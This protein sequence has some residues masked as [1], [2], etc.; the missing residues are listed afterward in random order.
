MR[1]RTNFL[2][3]LLPVLS[4]VWPQL[5][6]IDVFRFD[7]PGS[8]LT[9]EDTFDYELIDGDIHVTLEKSKPGLFK[10]LDLITKLLI[11]SS[12]TKLSKCLIEELND[13]VEQQKCWSLDWFS[14]SKSISSTPED[15][16]LSNPTYGFSGSKSGL[17][18][19]E[20]MYFLF[21]LILK[22]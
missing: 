21:K 6:L 11:T 3:W 9:D 20:V 13:T 15:V 8:V 7:I 5:F 4:Q 12:E 19:V 10:D 17:F 22:W 16:V 2:F 14:D 1:W 18:Q